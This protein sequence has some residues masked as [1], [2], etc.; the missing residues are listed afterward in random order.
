MDEREES[1]QKGV[2]NWAGSSE[3]NA[4]S[5]SKCR[6]L[7]PDASSVLSL[8]SVDLKGARHAS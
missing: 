2:V 7:R 6:P 4:F 8:E 1:L 5:T 3:G